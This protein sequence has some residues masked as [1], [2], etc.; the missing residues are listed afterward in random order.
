MRGRFPHSAS[1]S[2]VPGGRR[3]PLERSAGLGFEY[4]QS[5]ISQISCRNHSTVAQVTLHVTEA[6][7]VL[8]LNASIWWLALLHLGRHDS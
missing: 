2:H 7:L 5:Q 1:T 6:T 8:C 4:S 3:R